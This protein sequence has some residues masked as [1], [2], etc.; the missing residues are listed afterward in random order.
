MI[1]ALKLMMIGQVVKKWQPFFKIQD[2]G[3]RHLE[4]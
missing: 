1:N 2:G 3:N 4:I